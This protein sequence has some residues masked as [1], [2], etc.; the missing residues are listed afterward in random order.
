MALYHR[1]LDLT[2]FEE[3]CFKH[4]AN[5]LPVN[6]ISSSM[7]LRSHN[8]HLTGTSTSIK[9]VCST[10]LSGSFRATGEFKS[11]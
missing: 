5:C 1:T 4:C 7:N 9:A 11:L 3:I 2:Y 10:D 8:V 6:L